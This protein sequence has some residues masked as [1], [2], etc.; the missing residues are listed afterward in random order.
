MRHQRLNEPIWE[1]QALMS[2]WRARELSD[3]FRKHNFDFPEHNI[4]YILHREY[5]RGLSIAPDLMS[6]GKKTGT[7]QKTLAY[8]VQ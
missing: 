1:R 4:R 6:D 8:E 3:R 5:R 2:F 7:I